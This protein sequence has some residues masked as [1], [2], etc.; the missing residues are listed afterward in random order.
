MKQ[1][2]NQTFTLTD[3][4]VT[5]NLGQARQCDF[6]KGWTCRSME[7]KNVRGSTTHKFVHRYFRNMWKKLTG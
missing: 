7:E 6:G 1:E 3:L 4:K 5:I 2:Q